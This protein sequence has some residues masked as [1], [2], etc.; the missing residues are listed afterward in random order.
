MVCLATV[1]LGESL[2]GVKADEAGSPTLHSS[3]LQFLLRAPNGKF[4]Y[5]LL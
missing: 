1:S 5:K 4:S 3:R 2:K